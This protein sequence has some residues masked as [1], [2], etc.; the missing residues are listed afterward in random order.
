MAAPAEAA[1]SGSSSASSQSSSSALPDSWSQVASAIVKRLETGLKRYHAGNIAAASSD[2]AAAYN[3]SYVST[4]FGAATSDALGASEADS[5][6][7]AFQSLQS[8]SYVTG[9]GMS[10]AEGTA[11]LTGKLTAVAARLDADTD[12]ADPQEY[13]RN[14]AAQ[15]AADRGRLDAAK[16]KNEG[17]GD[18][19]WTEV[20]DEM[21][22]ILSRAL[23]ASRSGDGTKGAEL[24]NTAYYQYY[25]KLGFEKNVMNAISGSRVSQVE[26]A[27]KET[28]SAMSS[29]AD[30][31]VVAGHVDDLTAML[32]A[33]ATTL[34]GGAAADVDPVT[35]FV[36]SSFGQ[37]FIILLREGLEAIL[38]VSAIIA[39][40]VK[41][42]NR[43][44]TGAIYA[45]IAAGLVASG[46]LAVVFSALFGGSG[47]QQEATEGVVALVAMVM[48]LYTGN[49][50]LSRSSVEAWN[51][52]IG[53][54]AQAA[55][56]HGSLLSLAMLSFLAVFREGAETVMFYQAVLAM[57]SGD[58]S[59]VWLGALAA[60]VV[61]VAVFLLIRFTSVRIPL[62][63]FFLVTS[64]FMGVLVVVFAGGGVHAL[65][66]GDLIDGTYLSG[67]PTSDWLGLYPYAETLGFQAAAAL[68]VVLLGAIS[69]RR[70][71]AG[72]AGD[73]AVTARGD[74]EAAD[75]TGT[76][77]RDADRRDVPDMRPRAA[78]DVDSMESAPMTT[79]H[80][81]G[82][83]E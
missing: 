17:K 54:R 42:G 55:V 35:R 29:G 70:R 22:G 53:G 34:D 56:S 21:A 83:E 37:A 47:P 46:L 40:L 15:I 25:E 61:L 18:R 2:F 57:T 43:R 49:W 73:V 71:H 39:Y 48:L 52:Y 66:E 5:L 72:R 16:R 64:A 33:D 44:M 79:R 23:T 11:N 31:S 12:L 10:L 27:F 13:A 69:L 77:I 24:V 19:T 81:D 38:V 3:V 59:G 8:A 14:L 7:S 30:A 80:L 51:A 6:R 60:S 67:M 32:R 9:N 82:S 45:G 41:T 28:R 78:A 63:P 20:A 50:M 62:R 58:A 36:T 74:T 65:I 4:N 26:Y 68:A 75:R 76:T 1:T